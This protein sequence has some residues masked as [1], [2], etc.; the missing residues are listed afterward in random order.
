MDEEEIEEIFLESK[1]KVA[2]VLNM[3][4]FYEISKDYKTLS[5]GTKAIWIYS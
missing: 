1:E 4:K 5:L 2:A 3:F